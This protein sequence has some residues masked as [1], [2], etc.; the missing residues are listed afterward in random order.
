MFGIVSNESFT[1]QLK[2]LVTNKETKREPRATVVDI[3]RGRNSSKEVP[4]ELKKLISQESIEGTPAKLL[5]ETF[6][7]SPSSISAYKNGATSTSTYN[8]P[9]EELKKHNDVVRDTIING[10]RSKLLLALES[11]TP[12]KLVDTKVRDAAGIAKDMSA[13]IKNM[14]PQ[15]DRGG[16]QL[17]QQFIFHAPLARKETDFE[18]ID[19]RD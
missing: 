5:S 13:V 10:A 4:I 6:G 11:I 7:V 15:I 8:E 9:N 18:I 3:N 12:E 17:N 1:S 19:A 2:E 14:E 16:S